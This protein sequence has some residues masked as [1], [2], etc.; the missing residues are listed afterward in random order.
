MKR[1]THDPFAA[2]ESML[3]SCRND[4]V[5]FFFIDGASGKSIC[6]Y[7]T[8]D[9]AFAAHTAVQI[10]GAEHPLVQAGLIGLVY[11]HN[12]HYSEATVVAAESFMAVCRGDF[13][14]GSGDGE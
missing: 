6:I 14:F 9:D 10:A 5:N 2:V 1:V 12:R 7:P 8:S 13:Y 11:L 4:E 3:D